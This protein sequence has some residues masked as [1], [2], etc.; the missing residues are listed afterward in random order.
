M[1]TRW[2]ARASAARTADLARAI[3]VGPV[4]EHPALVTLI[5]VSL[6]P[7]PLPP[8]LLKTTT[9][10][11]TIITINTHKT[12]KRR[13][14][15]ISPTWRRRSCH[16]CRRRPRRPPDDDSE[17]NPL[18]TSTSSPPSPI[19]ATTTTLGIVVPHLCPKA[20]S[21]PV[22]RARMRRHP[23]ARS[24]TTGMAS[25]T[26]EASSPG[27]SVMPMCRRTRKVREKIYTNEN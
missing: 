21:T 4:T 3:R 11:S 14:S 17:K 7:K 8:T 16:R 15:P 19:V 22:S 25:T 26:R 1:S 27:V 5:R 18:T 6:I 23:D 12:R 10:G 20:A 13:R 2:R 9:H 24:S